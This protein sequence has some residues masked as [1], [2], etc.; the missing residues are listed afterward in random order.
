MAAMHNLGITGK[1]VAG[2]QHWVDTG[3]DWTNGKGNVLDFPN[4]GA[5]HKKM[6][7]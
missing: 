3:G 6:L 1:V 5:T 4:K 2:D 7:V